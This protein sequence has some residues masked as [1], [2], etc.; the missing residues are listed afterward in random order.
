V[1]SLQTDADS[2]VDG[3][4]MAIIGVIV[5]IQGNLFQKFNMNVYGSVLGIILV[6]K[7]SY[8]Y[9]RENSLN[10]LPDP[11]LIYLKDTIQ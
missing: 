3:Y 9:D 8:F 5:F 11:N 2:V 6:V 10:F 7:F 1:E 4:L